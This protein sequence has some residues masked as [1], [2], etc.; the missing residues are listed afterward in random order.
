M[1]KAERLELARKLEGF[2]ERQR[3][4]AEKR[5]TYFR[6]YLRMLRRIRKVAA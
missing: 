4:R 3:E 5:K 2:E 6:R 1:T